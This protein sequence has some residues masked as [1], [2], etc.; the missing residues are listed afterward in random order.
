VAVSKWESPVRVSGFLKNGVTC[1]SG[2][3]E[4]LFLNGSRL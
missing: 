4:W 1:E 2:F 3:F